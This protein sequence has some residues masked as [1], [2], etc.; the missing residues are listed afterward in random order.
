MKEK[1]MKE[2]FQEIEDMFRGIPE[3]TRVFQQYERD[4]RYYNRYNW[5]NY[6]TKERLIQKRNELLELAKSLDNRHLLILYYIENTDGLGVYR[7]LDLLREYYRAQCKF[8]NQISKNG[9]YMDILEV[10]EYNGLKNT[11]K[12]KKILKN[13][14]K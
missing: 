8:K 4:I 2:A 3:W 12:P 10:G 14:A 11:K 9:E 7:V 13:G 1:T 6:T 5:D